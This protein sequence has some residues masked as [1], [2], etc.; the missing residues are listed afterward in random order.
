MTPPP[1]EVG[2]KLI[3]VGNKQKSP[4]TPP[5]LGTFPKFYLFFYFDGSPNLLDQ[6]KLVE[7]AIANDERKIKEANSNRSVL[8]SQKW[9]DTGICQE[10]LK[11]TKETKIEFKKYNKHDQITR[12]K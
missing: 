9:A 2:N 10:I 6:Q 1:V 4:L 7:E 11:E 3:Q 5:L 8:S 12:R